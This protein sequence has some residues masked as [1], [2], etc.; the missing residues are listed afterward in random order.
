MPIAHV[1]GIDV[2]YVDS[3]QGE[4]LVLV[5]NLIA[6]VHAFDFNIPIFARYYRTVAYDL[7]GHGLS[8]R[9]ESGY[10]LDEL[11]ED[12]YQLLQTLNVDSCYLLG[13]A[14][15][16]INVIATFFLHHPKMVKA[17]ICS[18]GGTLARRPEEEASSADVQQATAGLQHLAQVA[19]E[20]GMMAVLEERKR[21]RTFWSDRILNNPE[22]WSRFEVM[23]EQAAAQAFLSI[24][25]RMDEEQKRKIVAHFQKHRV[26]VFQLIGDEDMN[27]AQTIRNMREFCPRYHGVVL[28]ECGH[29]PAIE[30][31]H[32]FN[33]A[34]LN[35]LAGVRTYPDLL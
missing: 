34:V 27:A 20:R 24:P 17:L 12:L 30:N 4:T 33:V 6:N 28:P 25:Q 2:H 1:N 31:P 8:S 14:A 15:V 22:I 23:Y 29:Y 32:D 3:G 7:R 16:G 9:P 35:F 5:H 19:R 21:T 11:A 26:P 18:S 10:S 13:Q